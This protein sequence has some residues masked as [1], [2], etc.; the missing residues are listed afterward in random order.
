ME[1]KDWAE[2][3]KFPVTIITAVIVIIGASLILG[4]KPSNIEIG[5]F[6]VVLTELRQEL[7]ISNIDIEQSIRNE[8]RNQINETISDSSSI[9][10]D[11]S[12]IADQEVSDN[13]AEIAKIK[14][15]K[16][17]ENVFKSTEGFIWIGNHNPIEKSYSNIKLGNIESFDQ[18]QIGKEYIVEG[19]LVIR[20]SNPVK[21]ANYYES[22]PQIGVTTR[23]SKI[24]VIK[25]VKP[26]KIRE[27][28][29]Q[30]WIKIRVL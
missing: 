8:V 18:I 13:V 25:I 27:D 9:S 12:I 3:L 21:S 29:L 11:R 14:T 24:E 22:V 16:G 5:D 23:G 17:I 4:I 20:Q 7:I 1:G 2:L 19:N 10:A 15:D 30:Y 28:Y 26:K 6:K